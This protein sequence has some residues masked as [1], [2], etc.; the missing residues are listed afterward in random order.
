V[1]FTLTTK[2][3]NYYPKIVWK[4]NGQD[5]STN[6]NA[7]TVPVVS[8]YDVIEVQYHSGYVC[9]DPVAVPPFRISVDSVFQGPIADIYPNKYWS[10]C[11]GDSSIVKVFNGQPQ[12]SYLW[13]HGIQGDSF[14]ITKDSFYSKETQSFILTITEPNNQCNR[15][16]GP[17]TTY[18]NP[19]PL[20]PF[21]EKIDRDSIMMQSSLQDNYQWQLNK[22][23]IFG[24]TN[25]KYAYV[26]AGMYR[27]KTI[28]AAGCIAYSAEI[29]PFKLGAG[30]YTTD[31]KEIKIYPNPNHGKF[32]IETPKS[33][34]LDI[35]VYDPIGRSVY[36]NADKAK[37]KEID[38]Q[39]Q[40]RGI[41]LI[42][43]H[44]GKE[45]YYQRVELK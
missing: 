40:S 42:R 26:L 34:I 13:T 33:D 38:I 14:S 15:V 30:I 19:K 7:I 24:A 10:F 4:Y 1:T 39:S 31:S 36:F 22:L 11:E 16:Y 25:R 18:K 12:Y 43:V 9:Q 45:T 23:D 6:P 44:T 17:I 35:E 27:V 20:P 8:Q 3:G 5:V 32:V 28:N 2:G 41:Y 37:S 29:D 21:I